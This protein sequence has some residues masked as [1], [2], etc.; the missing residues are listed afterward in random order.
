M[1]RRSFIQSIVAAF[2]YAATSLGLC[3]KPSFDQEEAHTLDQDFE[4]ATGATVEDPKAQE[5]SRVRPNE[6]DL[7]TPIS[8]EEYKN[9]CK[10]YGESSSLPTPDFMQTERTEEADPWR[11]RYIIT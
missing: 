5:W 3:K 9:L 6:P 1:K 10:K 8:L 7:R 2:F 4:W 11:R